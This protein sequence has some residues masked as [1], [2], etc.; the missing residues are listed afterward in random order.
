MVT[1]VVLVMEV[2]ITPTLSLSEVLLYAI[3]TIDNYPIAQPQTLN[4]KS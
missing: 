4:S 1:L 3:P 2:V